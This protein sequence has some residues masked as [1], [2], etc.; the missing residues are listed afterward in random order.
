MVKTCAEVEAIAK[1][2]IGPKVI[3]IVDGTEAS[4]LS[5]ESLDNMGFDLAL[6]AV[7]ALFAQ[8]GATINSLQ[9][10]KEKGLPSREPHHMTYEDFCQLV[11]LAGHQSFARSFEAKS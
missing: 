10:L 2:V 8:A 6:F 11:N 1:H 5:C 4:D 7:T 9:A 3:S